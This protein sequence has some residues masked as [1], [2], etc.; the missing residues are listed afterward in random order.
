MHHIV[1]P[2]PTARRAGAIF[3]TAICSL[4]GA[5]FLALCAAGTAQADELTPSPVPPA[6]TSLPG[7]VLDQMLPPLGDLFPDFHDWG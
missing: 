6:V 1:R 4:F 5:A 2:K 3:R 7:Q